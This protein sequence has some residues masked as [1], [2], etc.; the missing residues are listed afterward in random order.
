MT[1]VK[2]I[3]FKHRSRLCVIFIDLFNRAFEK[4]DRSILEI[5]KC[6]QNI[7]QY[8]FLS[9]EGEKIQMDMSDPYG[10]VSTPSIFNTYVN[11]L[12]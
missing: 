3:A 10:A 6:L 12:F 5:I 2:Q 9:C 7:F 8:T 4:V 11:D 1:K